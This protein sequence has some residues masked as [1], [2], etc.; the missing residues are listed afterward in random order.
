MRDVE[1]FPLN[2]N[3]SHADD[4]SYI[5][6]LHTIHTLQNQLARSGYSAAL[7]VS[8]PFRRWSEDAHTEDQICYTLLC[9]TFIRYMLW[10]NDHLRDRKIE[11]SS[12]NPD[13]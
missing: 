4:K 8:T 12:A 13:R 9:A 1:K 7:E 3:A 10:T 11:S 5:K 6:A 2:A